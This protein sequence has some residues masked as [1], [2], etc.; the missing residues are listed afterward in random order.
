MI[1][2]AY[3]HETLIC[4]PVWHPC[5]NPVEYLAVLLGFCD[6]QG[7]LP[8]PAF[9]EADHRRQWVRSTDATRAPG[10][11]SRTLQGTVAAAASDVWHAY[12]DQA[13][14]L[15]EYPLC[16]LVR[17][18]ESP[19]RNEIFVVTYDSE[20][21]WYLQ[22][23]F[24][25]LFTGRRL[26]TQDELATTHCTYGTAIGVLVGSPRVPP[27]CLT[28]GGLNGNCNFTYLTARSPNGLGALLRR[29]AQAS[30]PERAAEGDTVLHL[31]ALS[32]SLAR[33]G[34][35]L[36]DDPETAVARMRQGGTLLFACGH[37]GPDYM[38]L[39][40]VVL[41]AAH[42]RNGNNT[43]TI[44]ACVSTGVC[45]SQARGESKTIVVPLM[46]VQ[47]D[48]VALVGCRT[49]N[50]GQCPFGEGYDLALAAVSG[51]A[52]SFMGV[53]DCADV[54]VS[55][56][57]FLYA[58]LRQGF[59]LGETLERHRRWAT[60]SLQGRTFVQVLGDPA[61]RCWA[62]SPMRHFQGHTPA[63]TCVLDEATWIF[64]CDLP[65]DVGQLVEVEGP[66]PGTLYAACLPGED[67]VEVWVF[68]E[69]RLPAGEYRLEVVTC[70]SVESLG[71]W[72][73]DLERGRSILQHQRFVRQDVAAAFRDCEAQSTDLCRL[74]PQFDERSRGRRLQASITTL[75]ERLKRLQEGVL[76]SQIKLMQKKPYNPMESYLEL[77]CF[78][79]DVV[80]ACPRCQSSMRSSTL[81]YPGIAGS[82]R[83]RSHCPVCEIMTEHPASSAIEIDVR[84]LVSESEVHRVTC[85]V[86]NTSAR[87][88]QVTLAPSVEKALELGVALPKPETHLV[89][90][91]GC[92][93]HDFAVHFAFL[94]HLT[95][96]YSYV[97]CLADLEW[98][99]F[100]QA[101]Y[102]IAP[103]KQRG[104]I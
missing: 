47:F 3:R 58:L 40:S 39:G 10:N 77:C 63:Y 15:L 59:S 78:L 7:W 53:Y 26:I 25:A 56:L 96:I 42:Q 21:A 1:Q 76:N 49:F 52:L 69:T 20:P 13:V 55:Q 99:L 89:P 32:P 64:R 33:L 98:S 71:A 73:E 54:A 38:H 92:L 104:N 12:Y 45:F 91:H 81:F 94:P 14:R 43:S 19:R 100:A 68:G 28:G 5:I 75:R 35:G 90:A 60:W 88:V 103:G 36:S 86:R 37:A 4:T 87:E 65:L 85:V 102:R 46:D 6:G 41:C 66:V 95:Q 74:L 30:P 82:E 79:S 70:P 67:Q 34:T 22:A 2:S 93:S 57:F 83:V 44:P 29:C 62:A 51:E 84:P 80:E 8:L 97:L 11:A 31:N 101:L 16:E 27:T 61:L 9:S 48:H 72:I 17:H 24:W 23:L 18:F 50:L